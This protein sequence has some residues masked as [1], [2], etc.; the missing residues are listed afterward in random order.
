M[1]KRNLCISIIF[2]YAT[3]SDAAEIERI[4][5]GNFSRGDLSNWQQK[6]FKNVTQY[7]TARVGDVSV[8]HAESHDS[9]SGLYKKHRVDL[10]KYPYLN[11]RW[12]IE[13]TLQA[14]DEKS[15]TGDDYAARIYVVTSGGLLPWK[16]RAISYV[17]ANSSLK[18]DV[19]P[20]AFAGKKAMMVA[21]RSAE[22]GVSTWYDEKRNVHQD[23]KLLFG[24][25]I[26]YINVTALMTDTDNSHGHARA[27]YGDIYFSSE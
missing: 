22:D 8:L 13:N 1:N 21:L 10:H 18:G 17:W 26:R 2:I 16:A 6:T 20:N 24:K 12:R 19:W 15:K 7:K 11:W 4:E 5:I 23:L 9:A 27:Y 25:D 3:L 14:T